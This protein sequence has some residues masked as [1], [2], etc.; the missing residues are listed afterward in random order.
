MSLSSQN[1]GSMV[2]RVVLPSVSAANT[3]AATSGNSQ[4]IDTQDLEGEIAVVVVTGAITG[5]VTVKLQSAT[6]A[7]GTGAADITGA[8]GTAI[9][10]AA[11]T[12][13]IA[14]PKTAMTNRYLGIVGTVV[15]GPVLIGAVAIGATKYT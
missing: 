8:V 15:T 3:A 11:Q 5:S 6:D 10:T 13:V 14:I 2:S 1:V 9:S 12:Q 4:W 7:N